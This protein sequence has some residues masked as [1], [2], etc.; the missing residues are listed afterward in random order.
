MYTCVFILLRLSGERELGVALNRTYANVLP[1]PLPKS[2]TFADLLILVRHSFTLLPV[3][4]LSHFAY[5]S[6]L[7][8]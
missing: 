6:G 1:V 3:P 7:N 8:R 2:S 4:R 5:M